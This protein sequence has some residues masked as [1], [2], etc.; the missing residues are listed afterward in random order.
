[1]VVLRS[2][3]RFRFTA[4]NPEKVTSRGIF[5]NMRIYTDDPT[6]EYV[7]DMA[8]RLICDITDKE[9]DIAED[10]LHISYV[11]GTLSLVKGSLTLTGELESRR[12]LSKANLE[13]E[14]VVKACRIRNHEGSIRVVDATAGLG[15]DSI[16]LAAAGFDVRMIEYNPVICELLKDSMK[17][18]AESMS[19][20]ISRMSLSAGDSIEVLPTYEGWADVVYLDPMFPKRNKSSLIKKKFQL[21]H[22]LESPCASEHELLEAGLA[23][24]PKKIV[25]KRPL[26]GPYL[27]GVKPDYSYTGKAIRFDCIIPR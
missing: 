4:C 12:R 10:E 6:N 13:K 26:K 8:G 11:A 17:R 14:L 20:V 2:P 9:S 21:L 25:I 23:A 24:K 19:G 22:N 16:L 18:A 1:M 15:E 5:D 3:V 27:D 7:R